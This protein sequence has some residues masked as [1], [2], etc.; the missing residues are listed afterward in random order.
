MIQNDLLYSKKPVIIAGGNDKWIHNKDNEAFRTDD[1]LK[2]R[3][4]RF[5]A[6]I[7]SKYVYRAPLKYFCDPGKTNFLTKIFLKT[8]MKKVFESKK[9]VTGI[10]APDLQIAFARALF[11]QYSQ[12][13]L[14]KNFRQ[15]LER[16]MLSS[17][18]LRMGIQK[19]P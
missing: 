5:E 6:Q 13:L 11:I 3:E 9:K 10:G 1:N 2:E 14:T 16:I 7:N 19:T 17:K 12:I 4:D 18:M 15:Y 8:K